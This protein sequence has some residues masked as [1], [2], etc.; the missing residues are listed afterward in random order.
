NGVIAYYAHLTTCYVSVGQAVVQGQ[1]IGIMGT[2]GYSTGA[3][4]HFEIR[5]SI[6]G[7]RSANV[8]NPLNYISV[9]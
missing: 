4:L 6:S 2:T 9:P 3:H 8:V 7:S 5:R 1:T